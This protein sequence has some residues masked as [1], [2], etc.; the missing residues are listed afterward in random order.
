MKQTFDEVAELVL[1]AKEK[2]SKALDDVEDMVN[3][4]TCGSKARALRAME[5]IHALQD[6]EFAWGVYGVT[7]SIM[8]ANKATGIED[9][10]L[11]FPE[12]EG[13]RHA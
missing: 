9:G 13:G 2:R 12:K 7:K 11:R 8:S 6:A 10:Q 1:G 3:R 5:L 4:W